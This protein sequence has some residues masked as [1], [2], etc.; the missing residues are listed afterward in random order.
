MFIMME[1][2][3]QV[4]QPRKSFVGIHG[5]NGVTSIVYHS[6]GLYT[7]GRDGYL[8]RYKLHSNEGMI[9]MI[10]KR[11]VRISYFSQG[12]RCKLSYISCMKDNWIFPAI[13]PTIRKETC[14]AFF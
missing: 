1:F 6:T 2:K 4:L 7:T 5:A 9:E 10:D 11:K 3:F 13:S 8:R 14:S 12:K